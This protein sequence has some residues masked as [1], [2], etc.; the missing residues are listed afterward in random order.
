MLKGLVGGDGVVMNLGLPDLGMVV[1]VAVDMT[2][3]IAIEIA[4]AIDV[5]VS[6]GMSVPVGVA[7]SVGVTVALLSAFR[8]D[9]GRSFAGDLD[10]E[11]SRRIRSV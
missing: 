11:S 1:P 4:I 7:V 10:V 8:R 2:V 6:V 9:L 3:H 5:V